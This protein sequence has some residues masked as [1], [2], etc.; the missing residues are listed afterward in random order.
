M[1]F[2]REGLGDMFSTWLGFGDGWALFFI[3]ATMVVL[4]LVIGVLVSRLVERMTTR[5]F[6][7]VKGD[8][9][10]KTIGQLLSGLLKVIVWFVV[11][12]TIASELMIDIRPILAAAGILGL[13]IGFGSQ[14]LVS[15]VV[16]GFFII[17]DNAYNVGE[18]IEVDGYKG[19]VSHMNLRVTHV[20]NWQGSSLIL[21]NSTIKKLINWSRNH[22]TAV[23]DFGVAYETDLQTLTK[24]LPAF[25]EQL[26]KKHDD[27]VDKPIYLGVTDLADSSINMRIIA[28]CTTGTH[29][30]VERKIR[31]DLVAFLNNQGVEIPFPQVVVSQKSTS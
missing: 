18:T 10:G 4:W 17:V 8:A 30:A 28:K 19:K 27:I 25:L 2:I 29:V 14:H 12:L 1:Q 20:D 15:D 23:V 7:R 9:R 24:A 21:N 26:E 5:H 13:A 6:I 11:L 16:A 3:T 31:H 22:T